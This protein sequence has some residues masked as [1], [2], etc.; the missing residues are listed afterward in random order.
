MEISGRSFEIGFNFNSVPVGT[1]IGQGPRD[2]ALGSTVSATGGTANFTGNQPF[3]SASNSEIPTGFGFQ[4]FVE[5]GSLEQVATL[6]NALPPTGE[7]SDLE[8]GIDGTGWGGGNLDREINP[9]APILETVMIIQENLNASQVADQFVATPDDDVSNVDLRFVFET[10]LTEFA[11]AW[12]DNEEGGLSLTYVANNGETANVPFDRFVTENNFFNRTPIDPRINGA[13]DSPD[14]V[15]PGEN[16]DGFANLFPTITVADL[17]A[18]ASDGDDTDGEGLFSD[19]VETIS[20]VIFDFTNSSGAVAF[21][22]GTQ[23]PEPNA[24]GLF[25]AIGV[26]VLAWRRR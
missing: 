2:V 1:L 26:T 22:S 11:F 16:E 24:T 23:I 25:V 20:E 13:G 10:P 7:D 3:T 19:E 17:Q 6:Y 8:G 4:V 21:L 18:D 14:V 12:A 5:N 9:N 15:F